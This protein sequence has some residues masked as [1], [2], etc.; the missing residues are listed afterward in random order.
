MRRR[1]VTVGY[2][3]YLLEVNG[4][5]AAILLRQLGQ[6]TYHHH[7]HPDPWAQNRGIQCISYRLFPCLS[8]FL[9]SNS[10]YARL[11][12]TNLLCHPVILCLVFFASLFPSA[13]P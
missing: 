13:F 6:L 11:S 1:C 8:V 7:Y 12:G 5:L 3:D 4:L 9:L 10:S 2:A